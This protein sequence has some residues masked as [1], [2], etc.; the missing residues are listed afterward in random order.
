MKKII[1]RNASRRVSFISEDSPN[2]NLDW[3]DY[4]SLVGQLFG[5][6]NSF[7]NSWRTAVWAG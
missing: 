2:E 6:P 5:M 4:R 1:P 3:S 7:D